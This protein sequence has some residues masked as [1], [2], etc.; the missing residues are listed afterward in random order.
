M[1]L[2][3]GLWR[4]GAVVWAFGAGLLF[5]WSEEVL[6]SPLAEVCTEEIDPPYAECL[7][8]EARRLEDEGGLAEQLVARLRGQWKQVDTARQVR[9]ATTARYREELATLVRRQALWA[10]AVWGSYYLLVWIGRGF[11]AGGPS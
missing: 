5:V 6:R 4:T 1:N 10:L 11:R 7:T 8:E 2:R 9:R 3:R